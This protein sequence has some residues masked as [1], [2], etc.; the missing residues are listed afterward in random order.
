MNESLQ[1]GFLDIP[2]DHDGAWWWDALGQQQL[3]IPVCETCGRHF[4]P[5]QPTCPHCGSDQ[6]HPVRSTG[7]GKVYSWIVIHLAL[8]P[9]FADDVPYTIVAAE[10][11][12]GV[13]LFGRLKPKPGHEIAA[14]DRL[15]PYFY[16][17]GDRSLLGF[18]LARKD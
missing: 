14:D 1:H 16:K 11:D 5:P 15:E 2:S 8:H 4:F 7:T 9:A 18:K 10:L 3:L 17:V 6:W 12:E 13:R